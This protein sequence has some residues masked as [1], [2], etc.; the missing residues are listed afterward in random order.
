MIHRLY[1]TVEASRV[2]RQCLTPTLDA[3]SAGRR[4]LRSYLRGRQG[5][6]GGFQKLSR[7]VRACAHL[8]AQIMVFDFC[9]DTLDALWLLAFQALRVAKWCLTPTLDAPLTPLTPPGG[10]A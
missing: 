9:L 3:F 1:Q 5:C 4:L 6:L 8:P 2:S 7:K 10:E